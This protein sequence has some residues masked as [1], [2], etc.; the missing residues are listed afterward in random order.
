MVTSMQGCLSEQ[1]ERG[2]WS[3]NVCCPAGKADVMRKRH[4][5]WVGVKE[6]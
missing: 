6:T 3:N 5:Q 1:D 4:E 2:L